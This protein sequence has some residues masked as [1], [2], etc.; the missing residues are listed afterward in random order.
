VIVGLQ[1]I[2]RRVKLRGSAGFLALAIC[3]SGPLHSEATDRLA[4]TL[5]L[6]PG[7]AIRIEAT[8]ADVTIAGSDR[9]DLAV[10]ILRRAPAN[11]DLA[12]Y[13]AVVESDGAAIRIAVVQADEG[14]DASLKTEMTIAAPSSAIFDSV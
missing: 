14:R 6:Q 12:K 4:K 11:A 9:T 5:P 1:I 3:G 2:I 10:E 7:T 13:P 8:V